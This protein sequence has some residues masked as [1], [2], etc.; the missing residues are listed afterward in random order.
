M[1]DNCSTA[2]KQISLKMY[3]PQE[4]LMGASSMSGTLP[5]NHAWLMTCTHEQSQCIHHQQRCTL[6]CPLMFTTL[7]CLANLMQCKYPTD[8]MRVAISASAIKAT[9]YAPVPSPV[10]FET[11]RKLL[12]GPPC[13]AKS[14]L[15]RILP[16]QALVQ[17]CCVTLGSQQQHTQAPGC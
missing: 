10:Y 2:H 6:L 1:T 4:C 5:H 15:A 13:F 17:C 16:R 9:L 12:V 3:R 14:N 7:I 11:I 8:C